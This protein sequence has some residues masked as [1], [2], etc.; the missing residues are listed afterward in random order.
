MTDQTDQTEP[1]P[2]EPPED[3]VEEQDFE[4]TLED[5]NALFDEETAPPV[6]PTSGDI[7]TPVEAEGGGA[8]SVGDGAPLEPA[9]ETPPEPEPETPSE[10]EPA[11]ATAPS[12]VTIGGQ[13]FATQD[14]A[15]LIQ[16]AESITPEQWAVLNGQ[17]PAAP[18]EPEPDPAASFL[19]DEEVVD[20]RLAQLTNDR[21]QTVEQKLD[22]VLQAQQSQ[23]QVLAAQR[24]AELNAAL[25]TA[26]RGVAEQYG[27]S[28]IEAEKLLEVANH[29]PAAIATVQTADL[30]NN[31]VSAF[32]T[33]LQTAYWVTP[34]FR[35][36]TIND[37]VTTRVAEMN[38]NQQIES[39]KDLNQGLVGQGAATPRST[40][41]AP[42]TEQE[43]IEEAVRLARESMNAN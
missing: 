16:W 5:I 4:F 42:Q 26:R 40:T 30:T 39:R 12:T 28:D 18:P 32:E 36:R 11:A 6:E 27:L 37:Q 8:D 34:E 25:D 24:E 21:F 22:A 29:N 35:D 1:L 41:P 20:P 33:A 14:I 38:V 13:E 9:A 23:Q 10:P 2:T 17:A 31:P 15:G 19:A 3:I 43:H 7:D